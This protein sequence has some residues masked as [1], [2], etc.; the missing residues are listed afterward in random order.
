MVGKYLFSRENFLIA[1][2]LT[3][4]RVEP[5]GRSIDLQRRRT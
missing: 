2:G 5:M 3:D 1:F 4:T